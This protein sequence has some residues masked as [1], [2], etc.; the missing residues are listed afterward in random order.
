MHCSGP[1][2]DDGDE[3][4]GGR[5]TTVSNPGP[6]STCQP[7]PRT[8]RRFTACFT[9]RVGRQR[10]AIGS[11]YPTR[12]QGSALSTR[13]PARRRR[14]SKHR[15][16]NSRRR[17]LVRRGLHD[18][19]AQRLCEGHTHALCTCACARACPRMQHTHTLHTHAHTHT[20]TH[21]THTY[22]HVLCVC[23]CV[24]VC[25]RVCVRV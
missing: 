9:A 8:R 14:R 15:W 19:N 18:H 7:F 5:R 2:E 6:M 11:D 22:T 24:Y 17:L 23:V 1:R 25:V 12:V 13:L 4:R 3:S 10:R 16:I 20:R 21:T